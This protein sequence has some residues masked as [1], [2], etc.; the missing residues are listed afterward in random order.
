MTSTTTTAAVPAST[1]PALSPRKARRRRSS[2]RRE[3]SG[4]PLRLGQVLLL[5]LLLGAWE[6]AVQTGAAR[7]V[8]VSR[9]TAIWEELVELAGSERL[10]RAAW[11]TTKEI[12]AGL[13]IGSLAGV[14]C[15]LLFALRP[16]VYRLL[17]PFVTTIYTVPRTALVGLFVIWFGLGEMSK[18]VLVVS[19]VFFSMLFNSHSGIAN[20]DKHLVA[21]VRLMGGGAKDVI[22]H[23]YLPSA[24][25][26]IFAGLR[27]SLIFAL[28]GAIVGEM[29]ASRDGLGFLLQGY[30]A[31]F[32]TAGVFAVLVI[33]ALFANL[34]SVLLN[35]AER[36]L[37]RWKD[38][39]RPNH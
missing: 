25:P 1:E 27:I 22:R 12:L 30:A 26:W 17:Q 3:L 31:L 16:N 15:G 14:A 24:A 35:L 10:Y 18:I 23:V 8:L 32:N 28:T 34:L 36:V 2:S 21:A 33:V 6:L 38:D 29:L 5:A 19:L 11:V 7:E 39:A 9:P 13:A 37:I 20:V 4:L